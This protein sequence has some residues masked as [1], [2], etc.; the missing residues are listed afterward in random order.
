MFN[1]RERYDRLVPPHPLLD[2]RRQLMLNLAYFIQTPRHRTA[3][4]PPCLFFSGMV[5]LSPFPWHGLPKIVDVLQLK[6]PRH[7]HGGLLPCRT[8]G[9][10]IFQYARICQLRDARSRLCADIEEWGHHGPK[11]YRTPVL[12]WAGNSHQQHRT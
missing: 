10:Y 11:E 1:Q 2:H 4:L 12:P 8:A 3:C 7:A 5:S 9:R 6:F